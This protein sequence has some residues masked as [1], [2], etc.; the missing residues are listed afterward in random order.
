MFLGESPCMQLTNNP[1]RQACFR[2][3]DLRG[4]RLKFNYKTFEVSVKINDQN[5]VISFGYYQVLG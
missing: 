5:C 1:G 2:S 4:L 3:K